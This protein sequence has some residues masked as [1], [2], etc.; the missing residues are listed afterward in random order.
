MCLMSKLGAE[1]AVSSEQEFSGAGERGGRLPSGGRQ[2]A[3]NAILQRQKS[4]QQNAAVQI[5]GMTA[6][7][8][9]QGLVSQGAGS[10]ELD[11]LQKFLK[12]AG[13]KKGGL[14]VNI[15]NGMLQFGFENGSTY[16]FSP[17]TADMVTVTR[18]GFAMEKGIAARSGLAIQGIS[19][20]KKPGQGV[21]L[22]QNLSFVIGERGASSMSFSFDNISG[23][24][25]N[26]AA[27]I[28][29]LG[30]APGVELPGV[31]FDQRQIL[32]IG[33]KQKLS[34]PFI[35]LHSTKPRSI[36]P[37]AIPLSSIHLDYTTIGG[38]SVVVYRGVY[39]SDK[40]KKSFGGMLEL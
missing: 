34:V 32:I 13:V 12:G 16:E 20:Q 3:Q 30:G 19:S 28:S 36:P 10:A 39:T 29:K 21:K 15:D 38:K 17:A 4:S 31:S 9:V 22:T 25:E 6:T 7:V 35:A 37:S 40:M 5:Q 11:K 33:S 27:A 23:S 18:K 26:F 2:Y 14:T 24:K 1:K 8:S